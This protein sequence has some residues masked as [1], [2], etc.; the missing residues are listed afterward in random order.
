MAT[1][2][3][4]ICKS[5][6]GEKTAG[7]LGGR[8]AVYCRFSSTNQEKGVSIETQLEV[9][10]K[11]TGPG[12]LEF[13]DRAV[14]G[15]TMHREAFRKMLDAAE[16]GEFDRLIVYRWDRFGRNAETHATIADLEEL[17]VTVTSATEGDDFLARGVGLLVSEDY[18]RKLSQRVRDSM[19]TRFRLNKSYMG[20]VIPYGYRTVKG[21]DGL[22][23]LEI[24]PAE[25]KVVRA[26]FRLAVRESIGAKRIARRLGE[27]GFK[28]RLGGD[29]WGTTTINRMMRSTI[30][31]GVVTYGRRSERLDRRTGKVKR[32]YHA[33]S[34]HLTHKDESLRI[35]SDADFL[36]VQRQLKNHTFRDYARPGQVRI[37]S[38][39][40]I[41]GC[42]GSPFY[43]RHSDKSRKTQR[44]WLVCGLRDRTGKDA[45]PNRQHPQEGELLAWVQSGIA[46]VIRNR[47]RIIRRAV[48]L[49]GQS[50]DTSS[51]QRREA[52]AELVKVQQVL[53]RF[54][55]LASDPS[56]D[57]QQL[58]G[59]LSQIGTSEGQR[60]EIN[61]RLRRLGAESGID[62][63]A[64]L[65]EVQSALD[66][67]E[68]MM[69]EMM[70]A[71]QL[72][73]AIERF[74]GRI[75][76]N[77]D[78]SRVPE[79]VHEVPRRPPLTIVTPTF[80]RPFESRSACSRP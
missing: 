19:R 45:C 68:Q 32:T 17:G 31:T 54:Q 55:K 25:A 63:R 48:E 40:V 53:S 65:K 30:Y 50:L 12:P 43:T 71:A 7:G 60:D 13:I 46:K 56:L 67:A 2:K 35:V 3:S 58:R 74:C 37:F 11:L 44:R 15:R 34:E 64:V 29:K 9:C 18:S 39:I 22:S 77:E 24:D 27:M 42:C 10:R 66:E 76:I 14:S 79:R 33:P 72:N 47:D 59:L 23:R 36:V 78:G 26:V 73:R 52:E 80:A 41:C 8:A 75:V 21:P 38:N 6:A 61:E 51:E 20:G 70:P 62:Q 16:R 57:D 49:A 1:T 69:V 4:Q 28:P 5:S